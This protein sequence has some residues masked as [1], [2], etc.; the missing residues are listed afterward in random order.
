MKLILETDRLALR[1]MTQ[2]DYKALA[3]IIQDEQT[4]YA[5]EG[6]FS[7]AETQNWLDRQIERYRADGFGLW[8]VVLK[9]SGDMIGQAGISWQEVD[10]EIIP[11]I[12]YLFNRAYWHNG[13]AIEA[14]RACKEYAFNK[15]GFNEIFTIVRMTNIASINVAIRN[16]MTIRHT[17]IRHFR[18]IDMPHFVLSATNPPGY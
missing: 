18:G 12:G 14:A 9:E 1:E 10:G 6:A 16:G 11:E 17:F 13:Y 3:G 5:Y 8:A 15:L 7:E 4:M 2:D